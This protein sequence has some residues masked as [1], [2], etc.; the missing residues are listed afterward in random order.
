MPEAVAVDLDACAR[1]PIRTPGSV[2]PH[3]ILLGLE[4]PELRLAVASD[5]AWAV[6]GCVHEEGFGRPLAALPGGLGA[7]IAALLA[8]R[9]PGAEPIALSRID[10]GGRPWHPAVHRAGDLL[11]L[12]LEEAPLA[13]DRPTQD[14][15]EDVR[16]FVR[17]LQDARNVEA[18]AGLAAEAVRTLTGFDRVLVYSFEDDWTGNVIAESRGEALP[19]YLGL[20]FPAS[21][22]PAQA[23]DLYRLNRIRQIP[24][25]DYEPVPVRAA[26]GDRAAGLDMSFCVLRSVSPVHLAYMRNMGTA[27][28]MSI[29]IVVNSRLWGLI[30][31]HH[32]TP[33]RA[34][35]PVRNACDFVA[36]AV[37]MRIAGLSMHADASERVALQEIHARLLAE[38]AAAPRFLDGLTAAPE[39]LLGLTGAAGAA[40]VSDLGCQL[41]GST[42]SEADVLR[43]AAWLSASGLADGNAAGVFATSSLAADM[44]GA[45]DLRTTAS[46]LI[47][48]SVSQIHRNFVLWFRPELIQTI[49]W[50]GDPQKPALGPADHLSPR[51]SFAEWRETVQRT[52]A[53]WS[54]A[55]VD[56]ARGLRTAIIE[57]VLRKAEQLAELSGELERSNKELEAFSYSVSHDLRA[58]FR[59]IVGYAELLKD[60]EAERLDEK[61]R[62]YLDNIVQSAFSAGQLVDDLLS[63]SHAGRVT[64]QRHRVDMRRIIEEARRTVMNDVQDR[65]LSWEIGELPRAMGDPTLLRQVWVNLLANAVKYTRGRDPA[66]I[67]I[68]GEGR[69][70][71][72]VYSI[73]DNGCG[74]D[75]A[76]VGK[77]FGVFQRLHR[78]D[79]FEGTGIGLANVR[80]IVERHGG[81]TWAEGEPG[82][83]ATFHFSLPEPKDR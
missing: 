81:Q 12:E 45:E 65:N 40:V 19:S 37:A 16:G 52:S 71:Q 76:Y 5:N 32:A 25:A 3:G 58:P 7:E 80:R 51:R 63:F 11:V 10:I 74:F 20:R 29:S 2:Q 46:G 64:L 22:I 72:A 35:L 24:T 82:R 56:A 41:V 6:L 68:S 48:V 79:E 77:L 14:V 44:P 39:A 61:A 67:R 55:Q 75:M 70:D 21:D 8:S 66:I 83:G 4:G 18:V 73:A 23:R 50:G 59:H 42:P 69:R 31:C 17:V 15:Y 9:Q 53:P 57:L 33:R 54:A 1:E 60:R 34:A 38:V 28:S 78:A 43:I 62:H 27:A 49:R 30:S 26:G 13:S 36:Q 47:A